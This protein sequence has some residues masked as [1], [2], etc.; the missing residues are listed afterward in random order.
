MLPA[1]LHY[2]RT[3]KRRDHNKSVSKLHYLA[4]TLGNR[5]MVYEININEYFVSAITPYVITYFVS[6]I[7]PYVITYFVSAITPYV[8][9][10]F[11]TN[12]RTPTWTF[13]NFLA[14]K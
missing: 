3:E 1:C 13:P 4:T 8:I 9:T 5:N 10:Y 7:T 2:R 11:K 14:G 6:A 12:E